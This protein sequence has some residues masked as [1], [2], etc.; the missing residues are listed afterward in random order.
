MSP[1]GLLDALR[2]ELSAQ[3]LLLQVHRTMHRWSSGTRVGRVGA[4]FA[5]LCKKQH[6][7]H[8]ATSGRDAL[9]SRVQMLEFFFT[10]QSA[11]TRSLVGSEPGTWTFSMPSS[12]QG[13]GAFPNMWCG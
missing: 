5:G 3:Q 8:G 7:S 4:C 13:R 6:Q 12:T 10:A 11:V 1:A 2:L 9:V